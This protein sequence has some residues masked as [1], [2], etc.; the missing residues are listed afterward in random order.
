MTMY[1]ER[2]D[3]CGR[4][5]PT[6]ACWL[7]SEVQ[8][9]ATCCLLCSER[10]HCRTPSWFFKVKPLTREEVAIKEKK[11]AEEKIQKVLEEL[12]GKLK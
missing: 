6:R 12:L 11:A 7:H 10:N 9:C 1:W 5:E 4:Y 8:I 3:I 2:C